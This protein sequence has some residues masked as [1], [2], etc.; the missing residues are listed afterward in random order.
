MQELEKEGFYAGLYADLSEVQSW[1]GCPWGFP[2][3][4]AE[5]GVSAP[6]VPCVAWQTGNTNPVPGITGAVDHDVWYGRPEPAPNNGLWNLWFN[7][8]QVVV[9]DPDTKPYPD[10]QD[11]PGDWY[12][13]IVPGQE[14]AFYLANFVKGVKHAMAHGNDIGP[15]LR[16]GYVPRDCS[17]NDVAKLKNI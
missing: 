14:S 8:Q 3:F 6:S 4:L 16:A 7:P 5:Y 2:L 11:K 10:P 13:V 17:T 1:A 15:Y 9:P 12:I